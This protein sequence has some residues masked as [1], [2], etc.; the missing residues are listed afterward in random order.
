MR[1][2]VFDGTVEEIRELQ[3]ELMRSGATTM[4]VGAPDASPATQEGQ[5]TA[6]RSFV[7][8]EVALRFLKRRPLSS[9][10]RAVISAIYHSH[11]KGILASAL[12]QKIGYSPS[13]FA[14]LM[15]SF[16][17]RLTNTPGYLDYTWLF[18][19]QW[20]SEQGCN[21][22]R[23]PDSVRAAIEQANLV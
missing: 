10:Q 3:K 23:F 8:T 15:G 12:Q 7:S 18:D 2:L 19:N 20:E 9:E 6:G 5:L 21:R 1:M 22:Y 4:A 16:G 11:P 14:G 17:R 13:K